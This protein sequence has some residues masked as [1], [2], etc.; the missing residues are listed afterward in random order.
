MRVGKWWDY[1]FYA[2]HGGV[3]CKWVKIEEIPDAESDGWWC[4]E[5]VSGNSGGYWQMWRPASLKA[6]E[7]YHKAKADAEPGNGA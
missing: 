3:S 2:A 4:C 6:R 1:N 7:E 5:S